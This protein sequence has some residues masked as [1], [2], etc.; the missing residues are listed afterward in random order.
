MLR[1][2]C[3]SHMCMLLLFRVVSKICKNQKLA[4][5]LIRSCYQFNNFFCTVQKPANTLEATDPP[6]QSKKKKKKK[7]RASNT[8]PN[9]SAEDPDGKTRLMKGAI[10]YLQ[11]WDCERSHWKFE[12]LK[13]VF[14]L[15][16]ALDPQV[17]SDSHFE[18][19]LRYVAS[20]RGHARKTTLSEM[21]TQLNNYEE[22]QTKNPS[23]SD[24]LKYARARQ[25]V[26]MLSE[27]S[28]NK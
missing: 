14:L 22:K 9:K 12:K 5:V 8:S 23:E 26:Q 28:E 24:S 21:E 11:L 20:I 25:M 3:V 13:Q 7:K 19:L 2:V 17:I 15:K 27:A 16:H 4:L 10:S 6:K 18:L 1:G